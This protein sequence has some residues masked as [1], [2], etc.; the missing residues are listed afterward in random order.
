MFVFWIT[1]V[2]LLNISNFEELKGAT[3]LVLWIK[4]NVVYTA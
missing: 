1:L 4:N 3:L 2:F